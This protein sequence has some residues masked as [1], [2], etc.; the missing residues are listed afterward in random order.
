M[1]KVCE[2]E[3]CSK[4]LN[5]GKHYCN[6][7]H[8]A[9]G[10]AQKIKSM[11][12]I[13]S[14]DAIPDQTKAW[15][16]GLFGSDAAQVLSEMNDVVNVE[17]AQIP[18]AAPTE[19][20]TEGGYPPGS[21]HFAHLG[22]GDYRPDD[23]ISYDKISLMQQ[24][25]QVVFATCLKK[26]PIRTVFRNQNSW[27]VESLDEE[28]G[29]RVDANLA[30]LFPTMIDDMLTSFDYGVAFGEIRWETVPANRYGVDGNDLFTGIRAIDFCYPETIEKI[31]RTSKGKFDG[32]TQKVQ[33]QSKVVDVP[34]EQAVVFTYNKMFRNLW[35]R[36]FFRPMYVA[37]YWYEV[38]WR[39]FLRYLERQGTPV[40]CV[41]A[42]QRGKV[43]LP[44][45]TIKNAMD[46][47]LVIGADIAKSNVLAIPSDVD[48]DTQKPLWEVEYLASD[49]RTQV[50]Q[51]A[52]EM[53]GTQILRAGLLADR[54]ATQESQV[55]SYNMASVH[56]I[57]TRLDD[58]RILDGYVAQISEYIL[59][60]YS[61]YN[62]GGNDPGLRLKTEGLDVEEKQRL[63]QLITKLADAKHPELARIDVKRS[64][65]V[66]NV[67]TLSD[68]EYAAFKKEK[69]KE[70]DKNMA[71]EKE[72]V[73]AKKASP[74]PDSSAGKTKQLS[75]V[76]NALDRGAIV[77]VY[78]TPS[79]VEAIERVAKLELV[80][81]D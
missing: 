36:S 60:R 78:V 55:G 63:F 34:L 42:P 18:K 69:D 11:N 49:N 75:E 7:K 54:V 6:R 14:A 20:K 19:G 17:L 77:P 9:L 57:M 74:L 3:G 45:G 76:Q 27:R 43:E 51:G 31:N 2:L 67:P 39:C 28:Y 38:V 16:T 46:H 23:D 50:F 81:A 58:E 70:A 32:F 21:H 33:N 68:E 8:A 64:L 41:K 4:P 12:V 35:G 73:I 53:L 22:L 72:L 25:G 48:I 26:A 15:V 37:W 56:Y 47:A 79:Q 13:T 1:M 5:K 24:N 10:R 30:L 71:R 29:K 61:L 59:P 80:D 62:R 52:L 44:D 66:E 40:V 65:E